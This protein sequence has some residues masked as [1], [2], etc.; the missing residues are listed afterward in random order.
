MRLMKMRRVCEATKRM[1][2]VI[3]KELVGYILVIIYIERS[4]YRKKYSFFWLGKSKRKK[5]VLF[6]M[7][8]QKKKGTTEMRAKKENS[9]VD[10]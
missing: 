7:S 1:R 4:L 6:I 2:N 3:L 9:S 5:V 10:R 8:A